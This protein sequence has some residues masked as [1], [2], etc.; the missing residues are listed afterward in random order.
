LR[1]LASP[2]RP[3]V[4]GR[5][6][7]RPHPAP[8]SLR[9][10]PRPCQRSG[11]VRLASERSSGLRSLRGAP[12]REVPGFGA[13]L[14]ARRLGSLTVALAFPRIAARVPEPAAGGE[15][16]VRPRSPLAAKWWIA[17]TS[18]VVCSIVKGR[19]PHSVPN[20]SPSGSI[21]EGRRFRL[22]PHSVPLGFLPLPGERG[23][24]PRNSHSCRRQMRGGGTRV[25]TRPEPIGDARRR[26]RG[27]ASD[28]ATPRPPRRAS[29]RSGSGSRPS[30]IQRRARA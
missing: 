28:G 25:G 2:Q 13:V 24:A 8:G 3:Q 10:P 22:S 9:G 21:P 14:I 5:T 19:S 1:A 15:T 27:G 4:A 20:R 17:V 18:S 26:R 23:P 30:S 11:P 16:V 7:L 6:R 29:G 12:P